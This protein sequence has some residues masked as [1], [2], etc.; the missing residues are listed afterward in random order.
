[1][2]ELSCH[3]PAPDHQITIDRYEKFACWRISKRCTNCA[4]ILGEID[5]T[6]YDL[7]RDQ[8]VAVVFNQVIE[9]LILPEHL[10]M[11]SKH[12]RPG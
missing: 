4:V 9:R 3:C 5:V 11:P 10:K 8:A 1:M 12:A 2:P 6:D 7:L